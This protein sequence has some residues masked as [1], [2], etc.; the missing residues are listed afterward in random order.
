MHAGIEVLASMAA[1]RA[2]GE[3]ADMDNPYVTELITNQRMHERLAE[4]DAAR[5][6]SQVKPSRSEAY[7]DQASEL[8]FV[9]RLVDYPS[10]AV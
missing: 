10:P 5:L 3:D 2:V 6:A 9:P 8:D 1:E 7:L 4:A